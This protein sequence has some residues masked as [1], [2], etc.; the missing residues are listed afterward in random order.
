MDWKLAAAL[1][2][3]PLKWLG[4]V[5]KNKIGLAIVIIVVVLIVINARSNAGAPSSPT[6]DYA[7]NIPTIQQ[8]PTLVQTTTRTYYVVKYTDDGKV[9]MLTDYYSFNKKWLKNKLPLIIDRAVYGRVTVSPR[10]N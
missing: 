7:K 6:P 4:A 2:V 8:A 1:F 3:I 10:S 5:L 9:L